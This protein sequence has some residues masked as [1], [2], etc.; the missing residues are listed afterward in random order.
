MYTVPAVVGSGVV[1]GCPLGDRSGPPSA[2]ALGA[3]VDD[4]AGGTLT[5]AP[6]EADGVGELEGDGETAGLEHAASATS[7][8][9]HAAARLGWRIGLVAVIAEIAGRHRRHGTVIEETRLTT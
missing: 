5:E 7:S 6:A 9:R 8:A 4:M 2:D 3:G 1:D